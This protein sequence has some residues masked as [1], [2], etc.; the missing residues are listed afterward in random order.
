MEYKHE[1]YTETV[2]KEEDVLYVSYDEFRK[3]E[4]MFK[5]NIS[6]RST[7]ENMIKPPDLDDAV[8]FIVSHSRQ[9]AFKIRIKGE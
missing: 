8:M 2:E 5:A 7:I 4:S 6:S 1:K 3:L 9:A